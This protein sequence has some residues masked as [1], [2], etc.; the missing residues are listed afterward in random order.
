MSSTSTQA[1]PL[2]ATAVIHVLGNT[3]L[4]ADRM[5]NRIAE[6]IGGKDDAQVIQSAIDST[7][8]GESIHLAKGE[9]RL[10]ESLRVDRC[11]VIATGARPCRGTAT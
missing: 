9:Y 11:C 5:G 4:A 6:G 7:G 2:T 10:E 8:R 1:C 3:V